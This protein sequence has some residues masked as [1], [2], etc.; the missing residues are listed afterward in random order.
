MAEVTKDQLLK[1]AELARIA[2]SEEEAQMYSTQISE[3]LSYINKISELNTEDV[4]PTTHGIVSDNVL[5]ADKPERLLTQEEALKNAPE[6]ED[7]HFK[8]PTVMEE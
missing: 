2:V 5:R 8:V 1:T 6:T 7:G 4:E 3:I